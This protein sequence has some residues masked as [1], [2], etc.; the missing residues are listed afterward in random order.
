MNI[1]FEKLFFKT[2]NY[3]LTEQQTLMKSQQEAIE[4]GLRP[5]VYC[6]PIMLQFELTGKCNL[7]CDHCYNRSGEYTEDKMTIEAWINLASE[8]VK[9]GG[10]FECILSGGEPLLLGDKLFELMD[11]LHD[12]GTFFLLITNGYLLNKD[13][14]DKL[15]KYRYRWI[16][17][18]IDAATPEAHDKLRN[19]SGSWERAVRGAC[20]VANAG[21]PLT[22]SSS[23]TKNEINKV[24]D[25]TRIAYQCG[26]SSIILGE[27]FPSG[28]AIFNNELLLTNGERGE[29]IYKINELSNEYAGR[30]LI[31]RSSSIKSQ[32]TGSINQTNA[33]AIIR[34]NGDI[35]LDCV[36]P[37]IIGNVFNGSFIDQWRLGN[38]VWKDQRVI[39]YIDSI[40]DCS[41]RNST[42]KNYVDKDIV[43]YK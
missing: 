32:L 18:S 13:I 39:D 24:E 1:D 21:I 41:G 36:A 14:V 30:L 37:F 4:N 26:A 10:I 28:R 17:I 33:G 29:L 5:S 15:K 34:P 22:I 31:Q 3:D 25:L 8:I 42:H 40:D 9:E 23:I 7:Q 6:M 20:L 27:I 11:I 35:R 38:N 12:D 19:V 2:N 43:L 16:Q